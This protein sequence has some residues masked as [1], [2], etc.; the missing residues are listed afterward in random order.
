MKRCGGIIVNGT[1][2]VVAGIDG[3]GIGRVVGF[4]GVRVV[5][6]KLLLLDSHGEWAYAVEMW[7]A[8]SFL[9]GL[10]MCMWSFWNYFASFLVPMLKYVGSERIADGTFFQ[11]ADTDI[12][13]RKSTLS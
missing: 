2:R 9:L 3:G 5:E 11:M 13:R 7:L 6:L 4:A 12:V 10:L 8:W 1:V